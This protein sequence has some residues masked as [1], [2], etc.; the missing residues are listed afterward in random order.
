ML[1]RILEEIRAAQGPL[2]LRDL[3]RRLDVQPSALQGMLTQLLRMGKLEIEQEMPADASCTSCSGCAG[4][5]DCPFL[6]HSPQRFRI[7]EHRPRPGV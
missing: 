2:S 7:A 4:V 1:T 6:F 5:Q 3:S